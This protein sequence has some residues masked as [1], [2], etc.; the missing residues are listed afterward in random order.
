VL[1]VDISAKLG[2]P[3]AGWVIS[4]GQRRYLVRNPADDFVPGQGESPEVL[5]DL[6]GSQILKHILK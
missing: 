5:C 3:E 4:S 6:P 1:I 2:Q